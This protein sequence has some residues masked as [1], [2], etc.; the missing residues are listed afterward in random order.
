MKKITRKEDIKNRYLPLCG[1]SF[2]MNVKTVRGKSRTFTGRL[3]SVNDNMLVMDVNDGIRTYVSL[4]YGDIISGRAK[5]SEL[6]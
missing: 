6:K 3:K 2:L 5:V 4:S 1:E